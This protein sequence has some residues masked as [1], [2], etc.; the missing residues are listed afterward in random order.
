MCR[1]YQG[2]MVIYIETHTRTYGPKEVTPYIFKKHLYQK[3]IF[4]YAMK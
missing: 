1:I 4:Q 2:I 3:D